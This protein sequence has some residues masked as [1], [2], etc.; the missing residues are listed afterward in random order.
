MSQSRM[1]AGFLYHGRH[2]SG[3]A[4]WR[5]WAIFSAIFREKK[6]FVE[7]KPKNFVQFDEIIFSR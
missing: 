7:K 1:V 2:Y 4:S 6:T 5:I 3:R